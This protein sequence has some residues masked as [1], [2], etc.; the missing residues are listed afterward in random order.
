MRRC[1]P[2]LNA[3]L[4]RRS[5]LVG[6][7]EAGFGGVVFPIELGGEV[8]GGVGLLVAVFGEGDV[9]D[10][11]FDAVA[12]AVVAVGADAD[13]VAADDVGMPATSA[14]VLTPGIRSLAMVNKSR[15]NA[16]H[17]VPS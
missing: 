3:V 1:P 7:Q 17:S 11:L 6:L 9:D 15:N 2:R 8:G 10:V 4:S 16:P 12:A 13:V 5:S 14:V